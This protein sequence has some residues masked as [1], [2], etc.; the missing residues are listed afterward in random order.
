MWWINI[1][2]EYLRS[3]EYQTYTRST[4]TEFQCPEDKSPQ[5]LTAKTSGDCVGRRNF[6]SPKQ[7]LLKNTHTDLLRLTP[8]ELQHHG[9]SL[10][11]T[12]GIQGGTEVSGLKVRA[13]GQ[14][15]LRQKGRQRPLSLCWTLPHT[16]PAGGCYIWDSINLAN[17][18][19][20]ILE[21]PWG[22]IPPNLQ[23][24]SSVNSGFSI[25]MAGLGSCFT[26]S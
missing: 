22:S 23:A 14:L 26:T 25:W 24:H 3:K 18:V 9:S 15:S 21:I 10:T 13:G 1:Q 4:S 19:C 8:S 12:S 16:V 6:W 17:T 5:L 11:G 20:P 7:F 2:Q